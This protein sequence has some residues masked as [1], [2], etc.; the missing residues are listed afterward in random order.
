[1]SAFLDLGV[2]GGRP[3]GQPAGQFER[4]AEHLFGRDHLAHQS[5][6]LGLLGAERLTEQM[7]SLAL[8]PPSECTRLAESPES[9]VSPIAA[10]AVANEAPSAATRRSQAR[11]NPS[12]AP[13]AAPLIA[14]TTGLDISANARTIGL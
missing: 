13:T 10:N 9:A 2:R 14:A 6:L 7:S 11:A 12:P 4:R 3:G 1:V 8:A 5:P